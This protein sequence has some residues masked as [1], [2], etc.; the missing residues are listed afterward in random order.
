M[1]NLYRN[2]SVLRR[3]NKGRVES[4]IIMVTE[5][6]EE[7]Q[8]TGA[9]IGLKLWIHILDIMLVGRQKHVRMTTL[10]H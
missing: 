3:I 4:E 10:E 6:Q 7:G 8:Q 1:Q 2:E 5:E 9:C